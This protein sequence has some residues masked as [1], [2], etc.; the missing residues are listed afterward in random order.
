VAPWNDADVRS[1]DTLADLGSAV[2]EDVVR[3]AHDAIALRGR[4]T[5]VLAGGQTPR[6]LYRRLASPA[7][8]ERIAW[9]SVHVFWGDERYVPHSD[10]L[11][12]V[13]MA[14]EALLDHVPCPPD[15]V[16]PMPTSMA[17]ADEAALAYER[18]LR[19][20]FG[21]APPVF[22]LVLLG[23]GADGH[24]ASLF[25]HSPALRESTRQVLAVTAAADPPVRLTLTLPPLIG[26]TRIFVVAAGA[27]KHAALGHV[28]APGADADRY[29]AAALR[30]ANGRLTWWVARMG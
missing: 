14:R 26:A 24:T 30:A 25:P 11:S 3:I 21:P 20:F 9:A 5:L 28:L 27:D 18:T 15:Q 6:A 12:N 16:H 7:M 13:R 19:Q 1:F 23:L 22:D 17:S 8:R 10:P 29:P 2:A 4:F